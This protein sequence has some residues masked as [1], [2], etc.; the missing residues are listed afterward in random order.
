MTITLALDLLLALLARTSEISAL[1]TKAR[2][3]GRDRLTP[4]EFKQ[5]TGADDASRATLVQAIADAKREGR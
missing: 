1:I 3:E 4:E 2:A 5:I